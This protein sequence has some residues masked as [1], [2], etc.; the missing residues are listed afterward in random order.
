[1]NVFNPTCVV[2]EALVV[3]QRCSLKQK[4]TP[5]P[6]LAPDG[7][8][9]RAFLIQEALHLATTSLKEDLRLL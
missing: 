3:G 8:A 5:L 1:M 4:P 2:I 9:A 6:V 7:G